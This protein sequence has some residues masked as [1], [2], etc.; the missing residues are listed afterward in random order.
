MLKGQRYIFKKFVN[1]SKTLEHG[2]T[3]KRDYKLISKLRY[4]DQD[5]ERRKQDLR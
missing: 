1:V 2:W 5:I 3:L 4:K